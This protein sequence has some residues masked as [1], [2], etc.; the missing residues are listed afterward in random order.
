MIYRDSTGYIIESL[1]KNIGNVSVFTAEEVAI[2]ETLKMGRDQNI[3]KIVIDN[4]S[5]IVINSIN[6]V[7]V[8]S[9]IFNYVLNIVNLARNFTNIHFSYCNRSQNSLRDR[10]TKRAH[11]TYKFNSWFNEIFFSK[12]RRKEKTTIKTL[13]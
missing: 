10:I 2:R 12:G 4:E 7:K 11:Y 9:Q 6:L 13:T 3:D 1:G 8:P 5:Q